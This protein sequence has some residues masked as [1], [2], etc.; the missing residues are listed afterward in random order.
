MSV[1]GV[2]GHNPTDD[3][4][5]KIIKTSGIAILPRFNASFSAFTSELAPAMRSSTSH[6]HIQEQQPRTELLTNADFG[7]TSGLNLQQTLFYE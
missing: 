7:Q 5:K 1:E 4:Q 3:I 6:E 2:T